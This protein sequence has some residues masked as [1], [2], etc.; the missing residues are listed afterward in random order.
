MKN[1]E[2]ELAASYLLSSRML[3]AFFL[4]FLQTRFS[5]PLAQLPFFC[6]LLKKEDF[7]QP[8]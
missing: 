1:N 8:P 3:G 4:L 5:G 2:T 6:T 7:E